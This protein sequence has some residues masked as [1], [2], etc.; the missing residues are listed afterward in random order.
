YWVPAPLGEVLVM[1]WLIARAAL[2]GPA[3]ARWG[4]RWLPALGV[5]SYGIYVYHQPIRSFVDTY[6]PTWTLVT[7]R[8][9]GV[10]V[11]IGVA[12]LS[13]YCMEL[14]LRRIGRRIARRPD[15]IGRAEH[16]ERA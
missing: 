14:P 12:W 1:S 6:D 7:P 5:I 2:D 4:G 16:Y 3:G 15:A 9:I 8:V 10:A 11:T 13:Y